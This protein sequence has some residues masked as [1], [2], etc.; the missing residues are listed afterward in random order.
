MDSH[1]TFTRF[2]ELPTELRLKIWDL[3]ASE[4][5][6]VHINY[7]KESLAFGTGKK[8]Y[9]KAFISSNPPPALLHT[10]RES[11]YETLPSYTL[12]FSTPHSPKRT[13]IAFSTDTVRFASIVLTYLSPSELQHIRCMSLEVTDYPYFA[14]FNMGILRSMENL[15]QLELIAVQKLENSWSL[16]VLRT[17]MEDFDEERDRFKDGKMPA[18]RIV[19]EEGVELAAMERGGSGSWTGGFSMRNDGAGG[20]QTT[21]FGRYG[22]G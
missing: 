4:R 2:P 5:R 17:L 6:L 21:I 18:L 11:R 13:Y 16:G 14:H 8:F 1:S 19:S 12:C 3:A 22:R 15:E 7:Q 9:A 20:T 10:C